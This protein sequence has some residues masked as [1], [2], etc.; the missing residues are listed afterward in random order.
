MNPN[1]SRRDMLKL[2]AAGV[3]GTGFSGWL[4]VLAGRAADAAD[5]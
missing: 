5:R 4:N 3:L 1:V 2:S